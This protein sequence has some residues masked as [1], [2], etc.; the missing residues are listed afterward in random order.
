MLGFLDPLF[1]LSLVWAH[2]VLTKLTAP[3]CSTQWPQYYLLNLG[4]VSSSVVEWMS[5]YRGSWVW[6]PG[7]GC[8]SFSLPSNVSMNSTL[9]GSATLLMFLKAGCQRWSLGETLLN[10]ISLDKICPKPMLALTDCRWWPHH[11][12]LNQDV[13]IVYSPEHAK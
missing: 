11:A 4:K 3:S 2:S 1:Q 8:L 5:H 6:I 7:G 13:E 12:F 10:I 9:A